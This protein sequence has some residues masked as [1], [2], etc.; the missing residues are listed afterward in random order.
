VAMPQGNKKPSTPATQ[1]NLSGVFKGGGQVKKKVA[2]SA[3]LAKGGSASKKAQTSS[4]KPKKN[5][6]GWVFFE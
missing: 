2:N 1:V 5:G 3:I 6:R 4:S